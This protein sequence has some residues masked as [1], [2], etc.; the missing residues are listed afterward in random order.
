VVA[1]ILSPHAGRG[2]TCTPLAYRS[3]V[4]DLPTKFGEFQIMAFGC[5]QPDLTS[6]GDHVVIMKGDVRN[7][8]N[9]LLRI[10]SECLTGDVFGSRRCDCGE[11]L[12][13]ALA[14]ISEEGQGMVLYLR[15]EGRG[16]GLLNK[17]RAYN[18]QD[19]GADTIEANELLGFPADLRSYRCAA[20][21]LAFLGVKSVRLMTN[22]P[23]KIEEVEKH[24]VRVVE[25]VPIEV[26]PN[27]ANERYLET[28]REHMGHL[29]KGDP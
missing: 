19:Q 17:V 16:I 24:G 18:L 4:A 5:R 15:Q 1:D 9:L 28:K 25:R 13:R 27:P 26:P 21:I 7:K 6:A 2:A 12:E 3:A 8:E 22:N 23:K 20:C 29:L 11:Q 14:K 10:H